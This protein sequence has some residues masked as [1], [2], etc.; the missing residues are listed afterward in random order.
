YDPETHLKMGQALAPLRDEGILIL[1]SG[2]SYHNLRNFGPGAKDVSK[3]FD[4]WLQ[5]T[6]TS[7]APER[8]RARL[9][10]WENAPAARAA[11]PQEDHLIPLMVALGAAIDETG[12]M[13]YHEDDFMGGLS[14]SSFRFGQPRPLA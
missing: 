1:G 11:H 8:R 7:S 6:L 4:Q 14:V 5:E 9:L 10:D 12:E 2:L 3:K 13:I